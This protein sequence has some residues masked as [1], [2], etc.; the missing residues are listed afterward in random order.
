MKGEKMR[1]LTI[2]GIIFVTLVITG[3]SFCEESEAVY[4]S[5]KNIGNYPIVYADLGFYIKPGQPDC[6]FFQIFSLLHPDPT[7]YLLQIDWEHPIDVGETYNTPLIPE[8]TGVDFNFEHFSISGPNIAMTV[9][10]HIIDNVIPDTSEYTEYNADI[11]FGATFSFHSGGYTIQLPQTGQT[12]CY[13]SAGSE[14]PCAGTGQD[15]EIRAGVAWPNPR[16]TDNL[17]GTITDNLT[18]LIWIQDAGTPTVGTCFGGTKTWLEA[19]DYVACLNTNRYLGYDDWRLPNRKELRSL[20]DYSSHAPAL[21]SGHPFTR[22]QSVCYWSS[23]TSYYYNTNYAWIVLMWYGHVYGVSKDVDDFFVWPV[24]TGQYAGEIQLPQT[25][26]KKCYDAGGTEIPCAGTGQDGE[27]QSGVTWPEPRFM[28]NG[29][30]TIK[31]RLTELIWTRDGDTPTVAACVGGNMYWQDALNYVACLNSTNYLGHDDWRLP[32]VNELES[33]INANETNISTWLST[34]GF[35]NVQS[36]VYWSSTSLADGTTWVAAMWDLSEVPSYENLHLY[37]VWPV[38]AGQVPSSGNLIVNPTTYDF[39]NV[40]VGSTSALQTVTISNTGTADLHISGIA[41]SDTTNYT[42][43]T[44]GGSGPCGSTTPTITPNSSCT[45][46]ATFSPSS[47]GQKDANLTVNSDD[48]DTP[49]LNVSLSGT[50]IP[51]VECNL[52]PDATSVHRG[53]TLGFQATAT[54]N[55]DQSETFLFVTFVTK[56]D[57]NRY[58]A[59]GWLFGPVSV[60]LGGNGSRSGHK[61]HDIP[62]GAPLGTYIYHGYVGNYGAG[63]YDECQF[64]FEVIP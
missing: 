12:K 52:V 13:D 35:S 18:G 49:T 11:G 60:T 16:F 61:S 40:N 48:P 42:L 57:G 29:D 39:S 30:G 43:N 17:D 27:I 20:I 54:N 10:G 63:L 21:P 51:I 15:G 7:N 44:N 55:T 1:K 6:Y 19:L 38:R 37:Y 36:D 47:T 26:Q 59:S 64:V 34:Q 23:T 56:P 14:I 4:V 9:S 24:R 2:I 25:G 22:V 31:D 50:G 62:S 33:L 5:I 41:L 28:D 53:G 58:P 45:V 46:T 8:L 3:F 32:N